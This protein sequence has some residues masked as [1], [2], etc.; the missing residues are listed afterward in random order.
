M[1]AT[2]MECFEYRAKE[3]EK[4]YGVL[5]PGKDSWE[6]R[7]DE[8]IALW[9]DFKRYVPCI[10]NKEIPDNFLEMGENSRAIFMALKP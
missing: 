3:F 4:K 5:P 1:K 2:A 6:P 9:H 7:N 10:C 8:T